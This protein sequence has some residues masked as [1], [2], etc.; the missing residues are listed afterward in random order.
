MIKFL[1]V[2]DFHFSPKWA[3]ISRLCADSVAQVARVHQ[4]DF[5]AVPGDFFDAP[6]M[7]TDKGGLAVA[8]GIV[9][10]NLSGCRGARHAQP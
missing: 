6:I 10:V 8:R 3:D 5:I 4:V 7:A 2:P 9:A 1:E